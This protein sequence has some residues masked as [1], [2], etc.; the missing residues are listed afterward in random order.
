MKSH[1]SRTAVQVAAAFATCLTAAAGAQTPPSETAELEEVVV[2]AQ[3]RTE[4]LQTTP[5]AITAV[6]EEMMRSKGQDNIYQVAD[7]APNVEIKKQGGPFGSS[8]SAFVRGVGQG[9]FNFALEPGVGMYIDDVYFSTLTGSAFEMV[10]LERVEILRGPQGTLQGRNAVGGAVR[11]ITKKP[12]GESGGYAEVTTGSYSRAGVKAGGD[13]RLADTVFLRVTGASNSQN[14]YVKRLDYAC[15]NP[16]DPLVVAGRIPTANTGMSDCYLGTLGGQSYTAGRATLRWVPSE[17]VEV[18]VIGDITNDRSESQAQVLLRSNT[19]PQASVG[20]TGSN[21][22][23]GSVAVYG[24][25]FQT[26]GTYRSYETYTDPTQPRPFAT[27]PINHYSGKGIAMTVDYKLSDA[28]SV[29]SIT[30]RRSLSNDFATAMD[31]SPFNG[32]T[33]W[34]QLRG[35]SFQ[36]ELRLNGSVGEALDFTLGAFYFSS[37]NQNRNRIDLGYV[38]PGVN[39]DFISDEL[40]DTDAK[41][42]FLHTVWH[43]LPSFNV[44]AGIRYTD[45]S[46]AQDLGRLNSADGGLTCSPFFASLC[47]TG[48]PPTVTYAKKRYDYRLSLDYRISDNIMAYATHSTGFKGGGVSPRF[49]FTS[50][51]LPFKPETVKAYEAGIKADLLARKLRINLAVFQNDYKDQQGGAP[52]STCPELTPSAPCLATFN[53]TDTRNRGVELE[54][55][56]R[57]V[58]GTQVDLSASTIDNKYTRI[59]AQTLANPL[60]RANISAPP[61]TPKYKASVGLQHTFSLASGNTLTPRVDLN[62]ES[63]RQAATTASLDVPM[64]AVTNA[65]LTWR[66]ESA[67]WE[68]SIALM[69]VFDR[70]YYYTIFDLN[71]FGGWTTAQPAPPRTWQLTLRRNLN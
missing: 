51:I 21:S 37:Q 26:G 12:T 61:G 17:A 57:P 27:M 28:L 49:F 47:P 71:P 45:E 66:S 56:Y 33:G 25:W 9:D 67:R 68:S 64:M 39:F 30:S 59:P 58:A 60:F 20:R 38:I 43:A 44:T 35:K 36:Q 29:K 18:N 63:E 23:P 32:E 41:A 10:D 3:F 46:K 19:A 6:S 65:R 11:L 13:F 52:G 55:A 7:S 1:I 8:V 2:S 5:L 53:L 15:A 70:Y 40:A 14:G 50:H 4:R 62:Y 34:N 31:G 24:P 42:V 69:N 16:S 22:G 54:V 48:Y